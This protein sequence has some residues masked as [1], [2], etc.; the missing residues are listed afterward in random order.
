MFILDKY[1]KTVKEIRK[2]KKCFV[3]HSQLL[4]SFIDL[5]KKM[6]QE[7]YTSTFRNLTLKQIF[8]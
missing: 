8:E 1:F 7:M 3:K 6:A 2:H 5:Q 4:F